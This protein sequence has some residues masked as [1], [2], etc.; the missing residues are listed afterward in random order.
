MWKHACVWKYSILIWSLTS[1]N[2]KWY[3]SMLTKKLSLGMFWSYWNDQTSRCCIVEHQSQVFGTGHGW[4]QVG[5]KQTVEYFSNSR[6]D[7]WDE[8]FESRNRTVSFH[9]KR[10][11]IYIKKMATRWMR[12]NSSFNIKYIYIYFLFFSILCNVHSK[13]VGN[14]NASCMDL[15]IHRRSSSDHECSN[16]CFG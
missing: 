14:M 4:H 13:V 15:G 9:Q 16:H 3:A 2:A 5:P 10:R 8:N 11:I 12:C 7:Q 1:F 6:S